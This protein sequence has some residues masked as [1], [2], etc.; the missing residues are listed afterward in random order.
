MLFWW[1]L[2]PENG[3][4]KYGLGPRTVREL[5]E[6]TR[7]LKGERKVSEFITAIKGRKEIPL[8]F[9]YLNRGA[10]RYEKAALASVYADSYQEA[11]LV[12]DAL[13][14]LLGFT[15]GYRVNLMYV[16]CGN[17]TKAIPAIKELGKLHQPLNYALVDISPAMLLKAYNNTRK[18]YHGPIIIRNF[19]WDFEEGNFAYVT[20]Y[21]RKNGEP[22]NVI[23]FLGGTIGNLSDRARILANFRESM[24]LSDYLMITF[25]M[26]PRNVDKL[27]QVYANNPLSDAWVVTALEEIGV[28]KNGG[29]VKVSF[30]RKKQQVEI[31][32]VLLRDV[33]GRVEDREIHLRKGQK[34]LLGTS[35]KFTRSEIRNLLNLSG[36]HIVWSR[37]NKGSTMATVLCQP[38][39]L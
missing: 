33:V 24:T 8:K 12:D 30:N 31:H 18:L 14:A 17:G 6:E 25:F 23:L 36:F 37:V 29:S 35:H 26:L 28:D 10:D 20:D 38:R 34:V 9:E 2:V 22:V 27:V 7:F 15:R 16:G 19:E 13:H 5:E 11:P 4:S 39:S 32:F 21:M 1:G 3:F